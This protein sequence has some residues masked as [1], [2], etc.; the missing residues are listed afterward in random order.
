MYYGL[1]GIQN[2][3]EDTV[4]PP[5]KT[6]LLEIVNNRNDSLASPS[7]LKNLGDRGVCYVSLEKGIKNCSITPRKDNL[8]HNLS[9]RNINLEDGSFITTEEA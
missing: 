6:E 1:R 4:R 8:L 2:I 5:L 7:N 9:S 3:G